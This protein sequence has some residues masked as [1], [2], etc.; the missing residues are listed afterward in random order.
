VSQFRRHFF[1]CVNN[2][3]SFA[4]PSCAHKASA[5]I[6]QMLGEAAM[7]RCMG[8]VAVTA[9]G[10]LGPCDSG[11]TMVVYPEGVWY[12]Q[13]TPQDVPEI[14]EEHMIG[15]KPVERLT[16]TWPEVAG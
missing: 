3:P 10:C 6:L 5:E 15:G 11:P 1:V 9:T 16:Y 8:D 12:G 13:V 4:K 2:R 7:T 14:I